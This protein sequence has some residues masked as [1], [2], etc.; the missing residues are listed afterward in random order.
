VSFTL[1][2]FGIFNDSWLSVFEDD[3][4]Y[5][6]VWGTFTDYFCC[7]IEVVGETVTYEGWVC[8]ADET[9][10]YAVCVDVLDVSM[11]KVI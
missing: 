8:N 1:R 7:Y 5:W 10:V 4:A 6:F 2:D 9:I 3:K 11:F